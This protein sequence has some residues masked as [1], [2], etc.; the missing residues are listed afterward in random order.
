M[1]IETNGNMDRV[2]EAVLENGM[3]HGS[4]VINLAGFSRM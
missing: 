3:M 4:E 2:K 1:T